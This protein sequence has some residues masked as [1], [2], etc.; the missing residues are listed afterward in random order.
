MSEIRTL[1]VDDEPELLEQLKFIASRATG[2][3]IST[4]A[5]AKE[6][7]RLI[8]EKDFDLVITDLRMETNEAGLEVINAARKKDLWTQ[9]I[10]VTAYAAPEMIA[11][12]AYD[13]V[14]RTMG[15][16]LQRLQ[17]LIPEALERRWRKQKEE[18]D[19][20]VEIC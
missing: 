12:G 5:S 7:L 6:A 9:V 4:A 15:N 19:A 3:Q 18:A 1:V 16:Y 8:D 11:K 20:N 10:L 13:Y 17:K 2:G 14:S